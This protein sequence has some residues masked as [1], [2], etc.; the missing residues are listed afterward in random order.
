MQCRQNVG[1]VAQQRALGDLDL[2]APAGKAARGER[3]G[4][5]CDQLR[6]VLE[7]P[8]RYVDRDR[9][10]VGPTGSPAGRPSRSTQSPKGTIRPI[11]SARGMKIH[12]LDEA[13]LGVPPAEQRLEA[14][15]CVAVEVD[16][17]LVVELQLPQRERLAEVD[18]HRPAGHRPFVHRG[19]EDAEPVPAAALGVVEGEVGRPQQLLVVPP[20]PS[21]PGEADAGPDVDHVARRSGTGA[22]RRRSC[23]L[24]ASPQPRHQ[25]PA[26]SA[27]RT[28]RPRAAPPD[29]ASP[30]RCRTAWPPG[31]A[32]RL[33]SGGPKVSLDGLEAVEVHQHDEGGLDARFI[34][35]QGRRR[36]VMEDL[37]GRQPGQGVPHRRREGARLRGPPLRDLVEGRHPLRVADRANP[38]DESRAGSRWPIPSAGRPVH[39]IPSRPRGKPRARV[40]R[41]SRRACRRRPGDPSSEAHRWITTGSAV[42]SLASWSF[43][44]RILS[45]WSKVTRPIG[46]PFKARRR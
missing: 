36:P 9:H 20:V 31:G 27:P 39:G 45:L 40:E 17:R 3:L 43:A 35:V 12:R 34:S 37:S 19:L 29:P 16:L 11:S 23:A 15:Q 21:G 30:A 44:N 42:M 24:R 38:H 13:A 1:L 7:L 8:R 25:E 10:L 26:R 32:G 22:Q 5:R 18:L 2:E 4:D 6:A 28:R 14:H 46:T 41:L 33:R